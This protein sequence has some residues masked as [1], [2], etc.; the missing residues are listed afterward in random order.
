MNG[1]STFLTLNCLLS[2]TSMQCCSYELT[3]PNCS[4]L[5]NEIAAKGGV[6]LGKAFRVNQTLQRLR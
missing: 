2:D 4:L 6:A 1:F 3:M 5:Q